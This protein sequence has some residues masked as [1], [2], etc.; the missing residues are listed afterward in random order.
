MTDEIKLLE[1]QIGQILIYHETDSDSLP[2]MP[3]AYAVPSGR[4]VE[5]KRQP[6]TVQREAV[7]HLPH[8]WGQALYIVA[9][10]LSE[11]LVSPGEIDPLNRRLSTQKRPEVVVQVAVLAAN[12]MVKEKL[13]KLGFSVQTPSELSQINVRPVSHLM[14]IYSLLG[15]SNKLKLSG[16]PKKRIGVLGTSKLYETQNQQLTIFYP[17]FTNIDEFWIV[18]RVSTQF[19]IFH[20][21][22]YLIQSKGRSFV[23][24]LISS[25]SF[26]SKWT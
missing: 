10:L 1:E 24:G 23:P 19:Y 6:G 17:E 13:G 2:M 26:T 18:V 15:R 25:Q 8:I 3:M 22:Q 9:R 12:D 5:E 21:V 7:G 20:F 11:N 14:E 4:H 16:R